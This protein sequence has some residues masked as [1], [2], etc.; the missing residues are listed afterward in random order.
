MNRDTSSIFP[1][2]FLKG[3]VLCFGLCILLAGCTPGIDELERLCEQEGGVRIYEQVTANGYYDNDETCES[4]LFFLM[5]S[6]Y[7]FVECREQRAQ[8]WKM[9]PENG[10]YH[11]Q[12]LTINS[13][14]CHQEILNHMR[15]YS[16]AYQEY[17]ESGMCFSATKIPEPS[18][19]FGLYRERS[20][21]DLNNMF[22]SRIATRSVYLKD[23]R[24][25]RVVME[26]FTFDLYPWPG[27]TFSSFQAMLNCQSISEEQLEPGLAAIHRYLK[28]T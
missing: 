12:K 1:P 8:P 23:M 14:Q 15:K 10:V 28:P 6:G 11:I 18:A 17:F 19:R 7:E 27:K 13:G 26:S 22:K 4:A 20:V 3:L 21:K 24:S 5:R 16:G 25:G 2:L 9:L